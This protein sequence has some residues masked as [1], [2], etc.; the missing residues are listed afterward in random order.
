[1]SAHWKGKTRGGSAG[2]FAFILLI[3]HLGINAAYT[4]LVF[5]SAY[6]VV[7]VRSARNPMFFFYHKV[8]H[9][10]TLKSLRYLF[11]NNYRFGQVLI[12]K[13]AIMSGMESRYTFSF[14]GEHY[15]QQMAESSGGFIIGAHIGNWEI[16]GNLLKRISCPVHI[17]MLEAEHEKIKSML[18]EV[19]TEK[20]MSIIPIK[21]DLS[22]LFAIKEA[23]AKNELIAIHGDRFLEGSKPI[24]M[25]FHGLNADFPSGPFSLAIRYSKPIT[26]V[27][28][29]RMKGKHYHFNATPPKIY[30]SDR[31]S[32]NTSLSTALSEYINEMERV[33]KKYPEQWFNY[34]YFWKKNPT[35]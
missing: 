35:S 20:N 1:M 33:I 2:Y 22:H 10:N 32:L 26:Y 34:Y 4:L 24:T 3:K 16:A 5:V 25:P 31:K 19:M 17:V 28:A 6:F 15:L 11:L 30:P 29:M 13:V 23:M 14:E 9:F 27:S 7:F 12:D 21:Q 18:D 8:L